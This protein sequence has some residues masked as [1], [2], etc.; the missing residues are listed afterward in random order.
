[1][2][3]TGQ[4]IITTEM[5][6]QPVSH[7]N[8]GGSS[9][10]QRVKL[11]TPPSRAEITKV[12]YIMGLEQDLGDRWLLEPYEAFGRREDMV[13]ICAEHRGY[14]KSIFGGD[15]T[16][17]DYISIPEALADYHAVRE[18]YAERF[19]VDWI[20]YGCSYGG[21]LSINYAHTYPGDMGAVICSSGVVDWNAMLPEYDVVARENLGAGLYER[22]C[23]HVDR[24]SPAEPFDKNWY[25]R[26][27]IYAFT[28]G[29][30]QYRENQNLI[31]LI[32]AL[33]KLPTSAFIGALRAIDA[34]F[35]GRAVSEYAES[36][37]ALT[38]SNTQAETCRWSWRVWR[39]QQA[40]QT[41]TFWAP[42]EE[43]SIYR[44]SEADWLDECQRL[45]GREAT[46]FGS[47]TGWDV[48]A[49]A[50]ELSVPMVY[51][52]GDKDPWREV[53]LEEDFP[54]KKGTIMN[55]AGGFHGPE[56]YPDTGPSVFAE[57]MKYLEEGR[58]EG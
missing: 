26:E 13:I 19:P 22:L 27:L 44:R 6:L 35:T 38:L 5:I 1:M 54:L 52:R 50:G 40:F 18:K 16:C 57:A 23:V 56:R 30:C 32:N 31:G 21:A 20:V 14:G 43:R 8:P 10:S 37:R 45:F 47:G 4:N 42:S 48:R 33:A 58:A 25:G 11:L 3:K 55:I 12:L 9:F 17:P 41:G 15:Q 29:V 2:K 53:G 28:T 7:S 34:M 39:Y 49:M 51:V 36:N 46:V 24:L